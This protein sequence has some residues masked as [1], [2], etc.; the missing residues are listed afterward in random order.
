[1]TDPTNN[2]SS[3]LPANLQQQPSERA[4]IQAVDQDPL[5]VL[6]QASAAAEA[7]QGRFQELQSR[8]TEVLAEREQLSAERS[9]FENRA[10]SFADEVAQQRA[11][12]RETTAEIQRQKQQQAELQIKLEQQAEEL[13]VHRDEL[14][15]KQDH[16]SETVNQELARE[17]ESLQRQQAFLDEERQ[18]FVERNQ[19]LE[20]EHS[21]RLQQ[22]ELDLKAER[23]TMRDDLRRDLSIEFQQL[24][25]E[26]LE[27]DE[28]KERQ[29]QEVQQQA[30]DLQQQREMFGQQLDTEQNRLK[31]EIE[32]R[33]QMLLTEQNNLQRRYRFQFE[34]LARAREDFE[35]ELRELRKEQQLFRTERR[36]FQEQNRLRFGQLS[37]LR[38]VLS[39]REASLVREQKVIDRER[40]SSE[41]EIRRQK[42]RLDEHRDAV[43]QDLESRHRHVQ[44]LEQSSSENANKAD[45][46]LQHINQMRSELDAQQRD[47]LEQ[48]LLLEE[49][50]SIPMV[51]GEHTEEAIN[52]ARQA[53]ETF[54]ETLHGRLKIEGLRLN[55]Q[56][57]D[58][59]AKQ[60]QFRTDRV[61]LERWFAEQEQQVVEADVSNRS[62]E[63]RRRISELEAELTEAGRQFDD[64]QKTHESV[65]RQLLDQ[66]ADHQAQRINQPSGQQGKAA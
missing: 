53:V 50:N 31:E 59:T 40:M 19:L 18:K 48:R 26:R 57:Q 32:K 12:Q 7:L 29:A 27:W 52:Q 11:L 56:L 62:D 15:R 30:D 21:A 14:A 38:E 37:G 36:T 28:E 54:F 39:D 51:A 42:E 17:R 9:T 20:E 5:Q 23:E 34:H 16:L 33:R 3:H 47:I 46:R 4:E 66:I 63:L 60:E 1:M 43:M 2:P 41:L 58:L 44:Q 24:N 61:E 55:D 49:R 6:L 45:Q 10:K 13:E 65:V 35:L 25:R 22:V 8:Q 64:A